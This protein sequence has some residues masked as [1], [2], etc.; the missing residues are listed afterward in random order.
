MNVKHETERRIPEEEEE[1][2]GLS[3]YHREG[4]L[5]RL[6]LDRLFHF[7]IEKPQ[8]DDD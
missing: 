6:N 3:L 7:P 8:R 2:E 4:D 1:E 5:R